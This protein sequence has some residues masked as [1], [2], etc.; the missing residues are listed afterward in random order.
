MRHAK[1]PAYLAES[2]LTGLPTLGNR[3]ELRRVPTVSSIVSGAP[4]WDFGGA[5]VPSSPITRLASPSA[6]SLAL[7]PEH[8]FLRPHSRASSMGPETHSPRISLHHWAERTASY[9]ESQPPT[10]TESIS[11]AMLQNGYAQGHHSHSHSHGHSHGHAHKHGNGNG[12]SRTNSGSAWSS[13]QP[14][15][16]GSESS[17][18]GAAAAGS[19]AS[20]FRLR[21]GRSGSS[22]HTP[23][24]DTVQQHVVSPSASVGGIAGGISGLALDGGVVV[25]EPI[26]IRLDSA[27]D[28]ESSS[29]SGHHPGRPT[30]LAPPRLDARRERERQRQ[31][32]PDARARSGGIRCACTAVVG[33]ARCWI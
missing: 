21:R 33:T 16:S 5:S 6:H 27:M 19:P 8:S 13:H 29:G 9:F 10:P 15:R 28:S 12:H 30:P 32:G 14:R 17:V 31:C 4:S 11:G 1:R 26:A 25:S 2:L 22:F 23:G 7:S 20:K 3:Q 24:L 18:R